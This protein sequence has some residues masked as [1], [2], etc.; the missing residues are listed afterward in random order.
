MPVADFF[1]G[2]ADYLTG[3]TQHKYGSS[4]HCLDERDG[5]LLG[6]TYRRRRGQGKTERQKKDRDTWGGGWGGERGKEEERR[7]KKE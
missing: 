4:L 5:Q 2:N 3:K 6:E 1:R 7:R